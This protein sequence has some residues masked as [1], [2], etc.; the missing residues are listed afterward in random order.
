M[1]EATP[2]PSTNWVTEE[3]FRE[4]AD[5]IKNMS[6]EEL[7]KYVDMAKNPRSC[8]PETCHGQCQGMGS[9]EDARKFREEA[10]GLE[11]GKLPSALELW[12][13][14]GGLIDDIQ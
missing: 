9:C 11:D 8:T 2:D 10:F 6:D 3:T 12:K 7:Q 14:G 5:T 13:D 4:I 1:S